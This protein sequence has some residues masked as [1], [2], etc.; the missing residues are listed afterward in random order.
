MKP[1]TRFLFANLPR[2]LVV[3]IL[4]LAARPDFTHIG[5]G[6][7]TRINPYATTLALCGVSTDFRRIALRMM[8]ETVF[9][10]KDYQMIAFLQA[11]RMQKQY[12]AQESRLCVD[13]AAHIRRIWVD[14]LCKPYGVSTCKWGRPCIAK[15][16]AINFSILSPVLLAAPSLAFN[17]KSLFLLYGCL[18]HAWRSRLKT[19]VHK[20]SPPPWNTKTLTLTGLLDPSC[21]RTSTPRTSAFFSSISRLIFLNHAISDT[22]PAQDAEDLE[23]PAWIMKFPWAYFKN[24]QTF[25]FPLPHIVFPHVEARDMSGR[26]VHLLT[27]SAPP[28]SN[29]WDHLSEPQPSGD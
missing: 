27:L 29:H 15:K 17:T 28:M 19:T 21:L 5:Y 6:V 22:D 8:L 9:L 12:L 20:S 3:L 14:W 25:L 10:W 11:L 4:T 26:R 23:I 18:H 7:V 24:L 16:P 2:E 13:Y 1:G